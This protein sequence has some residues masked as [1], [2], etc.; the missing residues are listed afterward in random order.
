MAAEK[1]E[2]HCTR[3]IFRSCRQH[4]YVEW[5]RSKAEKSHQVAQAGLVQTSIIS[6]YRKR[7]ILNEH[8]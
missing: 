5:V 6:F 4:N 3:T 8:S 7:N 1:I 2:D